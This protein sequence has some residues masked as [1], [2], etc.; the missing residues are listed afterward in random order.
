MNNTKKEYNSKVRK[1]K[2]SELQK[3]LNKLNKDLIK[4]NVLIQKKVNP[5]G[6]RLTEEGTEKDDSI[7]NDNTRFNMKM[8][9]YMKSIVTQEL[10]NKLV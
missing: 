3:E 1:M 9:K 2:V 4:G 5:Y 10:N 8:L 7:Y 6:S